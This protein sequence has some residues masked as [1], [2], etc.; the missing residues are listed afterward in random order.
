VLVLLLVV[1]LLPVDFDHEHEQE[2][3]YEGT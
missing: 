2:H 3:D 1:D